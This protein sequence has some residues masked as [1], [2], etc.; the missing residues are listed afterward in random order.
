MGLSQACPSQNDKSC[1]VSC[2][3]PQ[4][5]N[6]CI[7]LG[8]SLID[9]SPCG[10]G[11]SHSRLNTL[12]INKRVQD[13]GAIARME[14]VKQAACSIRQRYVY[15][16]ARSLVVVFLRRATRLRRTRARAKTLALTCFPSHTGMVRFESADLHPG[17]CH[18]RHHLDT[19]RLGPGNVYVA[20]FFLVVPCLVPRSRGAG[21][22]D[23]VRVQA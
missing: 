16:R 22:D 11:F 14:H 19:P 15:R 10:K 21:A 6:R 17:D 5:A 8:S 23:R 9:G 4:S 2:Q 12:L 13:T 1:S 20:L 3:D 7:V 18:R